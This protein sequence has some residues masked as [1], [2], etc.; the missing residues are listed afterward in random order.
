MSETVIYSKA[1][2]ERRPE[3][4]QLTRIMTDGTRRWVRKSTVGPAAADHIR[5]FDANLKALTASLRPGH[6]VDMIPCRVNADGSVD[7]PFLEDPTLGARLAGLDRDAYIQAVQ[8]FQDALTASFETCAFEPS[9]GFRGFFGF[10]PDAVGTPAL[11]VANA[12]LNFDNVFCAPDGR[13]AIIDYEWVLPFPL[14]VSFLIYRSLVLDPAFNAFPRDQRR[15][16]MAQFGVSERLEKQYHWMEMAFLAAISPDE[17]KLDYYARVPGARQNSVYPFRYLTALPAETDRLIRENARLNALY[18]GSANTLWFRA[19]DKLRR[20]WLNYKERMQPV[21]EK[22]RALGAMWKAASLLLH[23]GPQGLILKIWDKVESRV[24]TQR[25]MKQLAAPLPAAGGDVPETVK[26]SILVPLYNTP[27]DFLREMI[28]S[29]QKQTYSNW[30]LCLSDGSDEDHP[31]VGEV[32]RAL[33]GTDPRI[34]YRKLEHNGGISE[35]TNACIEMATGDYIA[36]FDHDDLLHPSALYE[37]ARAIREQD[38]DFIYSDE[39][40]FLSPDVTNLVAIRFKPDFSPESLHSN[41]YICH[42]SVFRRALLEK[43]G[44]FRKAFD[45][46]QDH[47]IILRLTDAAQ[48]VVHIPRVLYF[49]RSHPASVASDIGAKTYA[50]DAGRNAVRDFL[51]T[52]RGMDATVESTPEYPTMYHVQYPCD[53]KRLVE[54]ILDWT[55]RDR[56]SLAASLER[57]M[58]ATGYPRMGYIVVAEDGPTEEERLRFPWVKWIVTAAKGRAARLNEAARA[59]EGDFLAF[60]DPDLSCEAWDWVEQMAMLAGQDGIGAVGGK[61][62]F[63]DQTLRHAGLILGMGRKRL[64]GRSHFLTLRETSGYFGQLAIVGNVSAVS[65]ECMLVSRA[66]FEGAGGFDEAL[67]DALFDVD[68][69]LKLTQAGYRNVFTPFSV[70]VGGDPRQYALD[71]GVESPGYAGSA[72]RLRAKWPEAFEKPDP[73]YNPNLTLKATDYSIRMR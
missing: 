16:V 40:V 3:Y 51:A 1:S 7:F 42:L 55:G 23:K 46:S 33:A 14:P 36:L 48:K 12:D 17:Y 32:C 37:N 50:V 65:S 25:F 18:Y 44:G 15:A 52:H 34:V 59:A 73:Y 53:R 31:E 4:R 62:Y 57:L 27:E 72:Q 56:G 8:A 39:A 10:I 54:V 67:G 22:H 26:F 29:V 38:A 68:L 30:E 43:T 9:D 64:A 35:N 5:A 20:T 70:F 11:R 49:W 71:Y 66:R 60:M 45:G 47:D 21:L 58:G 63:A 61:L 28:A 69:C 2:V 19:I 6:S 24:A 41:N 13:Y